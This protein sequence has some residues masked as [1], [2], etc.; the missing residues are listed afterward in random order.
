MSYNNTVID[1]SCTKF[2]VGPCNSIEKE[3]TKNE[4]L[5]PYSG[6]KYKEFC[7]PIDEDSYL[8]LKN[9]RVCSSCNERYMEFYDEND[10]ESLKRD[11][12]TICNKLGI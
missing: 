6:G 3:T 4:F 5:K 10:I 9:V 12:K 1:V 8:I 11:A 7:Y 2:C